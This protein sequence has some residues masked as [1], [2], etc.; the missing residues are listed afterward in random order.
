MRTDGAPSFEKRMLCSE[1]CPGKGAIL[2]EGKWSRIIHVKKLIRKIH[3]PTKVYSSHVGWEIY[4]DHPDYGLHE[5]SKTRQPG[6]KISVR[7]W[8]KSETWEERQ[9]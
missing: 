3:S 2:V 8:L 5:P 1:L 7:F 6:A 4:T 9:R